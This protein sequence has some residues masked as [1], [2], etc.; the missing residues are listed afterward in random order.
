VEVAPNGNHAQLTQTTKA[1]A[2]E[3]LRKNSREAAAAV[4]AFTDDELE[5]A[6]FRAELRAP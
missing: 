1:E 3:L 6:P 2:L 4:R 5:R